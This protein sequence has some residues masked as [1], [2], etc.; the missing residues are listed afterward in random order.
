[1]QQNKALFFGIIG[2]AVLIVVVLIVAR[3]F[4]ADQLPLPNLAQKVSIRIVAAP[5]IKPWVDQAAQTFNQRNPNTQVE[6]VEAEGLLP[7]AQFRSD[8]Q[9][10]PPAA[11][12]AEASFV[13]DMAGSSGLQFNNLRSVASTGLAWGAFADKQNAFAQKYGSLSWTSVH[14]K[15]VGADDFLTLVLASPQNSA[16]G[17]AAL[18]SATAAS[19]NKQDLSAADVS[20]A[21]SWL[22]ETFRENVRLPIPAK[23]AEAFAGTQGRSLGDT[24]ILALASWR[25]VGLDK[26]ADFTLTPAQPNVNLDYPLAVFSQ[27]APEAQQAAAA[28]GDFLLSEEQQNALAIVFLERANAAQPGVKASGEAAQRLLDWA[29]RELP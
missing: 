3:F 6:I 15:A 7:A 21:D 4:L 1:M 13:V 12:L 23:P 18:I 11:W 22:T 25:Q 16:E 17:L 8:P 5:S 9:T 28:F 14:T 20:Q 10:T 19:L 29:R 2:L 24:G 27:A 26:K